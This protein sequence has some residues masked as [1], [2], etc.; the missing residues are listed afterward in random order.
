[1]WIAPEDKDPIVRHE[2]NRKSIGFFGAFFLALILSPLVGIIA[3]LISKDDSEIR[4]EK[5]ILETQEKQQ[6]TLE[7]ISEQTIQNPAYS[8]S[9]EILKLKKLQTDGII[10][11]AEFEAQ[12]KKLLGR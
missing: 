12:K 3:A 8:V 1:M 9:D 10:S 4:R 11:D 6:K 5:R 7:K 2:P